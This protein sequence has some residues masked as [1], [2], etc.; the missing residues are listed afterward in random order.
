VDH[1]RATNVGGPYMYIYL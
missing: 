1:V